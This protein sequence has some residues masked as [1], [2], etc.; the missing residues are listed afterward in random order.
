VSYTRQ[1][2]SSKENISP[3]ARRLGDRLFSTP[4]IHIRG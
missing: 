2:K 3:D 4:S 1:C